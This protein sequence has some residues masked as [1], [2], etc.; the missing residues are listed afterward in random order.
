M[1]CIVYFKLCECM[2]LYYISDFSNISYISLFNFTILT[3][4]NIVNNTNI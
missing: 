2:V 4:K 3:I 1:I